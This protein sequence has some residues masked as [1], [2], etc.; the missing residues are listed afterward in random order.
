MGK[1]GGPLFLKAFLYYSA[2]WSSAFF[3]TVGKSCLRDYSILHTSTPLSKSL[4]QTLHSGQVAGPFYPAHNLAQFFTVVYIRKPF[5]K[6]LP[7]YSFQWA[8]PSAHNSLKPFCTILYSG[9]S[10]IRARFYKNHPP[11]S[12]QWASLGAQYSLTPSVSSST[13]V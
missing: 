2:Q 9:Q 3:C 7:H 10:Y 11:Y 5:P 8:S 12:A 1:S 4:P 6:T 13:V